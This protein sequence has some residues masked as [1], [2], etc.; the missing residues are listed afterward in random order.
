MKYSVYYRLLWAVFVHE[1][2]FKKT[3]FTKLME[4]ALTQELL[5][6]KEMFNFRY[7]YIQEN[8]QGI[9]LSGVNTNSGCIWFKSNLWWWWWW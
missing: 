5:K 7:E 4:V 3:E 1:N 9:S 8:F 2:D 6:N